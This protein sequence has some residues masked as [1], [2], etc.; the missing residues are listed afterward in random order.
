VQH[1]HSLLGSATFALS[2]CLLLGLLSLLCLCALLHSHLSGT[3]LLHHLRSFILFA[4]KEIVR[5]LLVIFYDSL[6]L[7]VLL[8]IQTLDR[9]LYVFLLDASLIKEVVVG[10]QLLD[11]DYSV[12]HLWG[13]SLASH[14]LIHFLLGLE[15]GSLKSPH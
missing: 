6:K 13:N 14:K 3:S 4:C 2:L 10:L 9:W 8:K 15:F 5:L 12:D 1:K 11:L 7:L